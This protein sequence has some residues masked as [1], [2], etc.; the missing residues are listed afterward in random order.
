MAKL[1][2]QVAL[3]RE[4]RLKA[5]ELWS[6]KGARFACGHVLAFVQVARG[7]KSVRPLRPVQPGVWKETLLCGKC[8]F[9]LRRAGKIPKEK[10]LTRQ[11][12][13]VM[14]A[15]AWLREYLAEQ[16]GTAPLSAFTTKNGE[17]PPFGIT[18]L[19]SALKNLG[20]TEEK[21][22]PRGRKYWKLPITP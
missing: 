4:E 11:A 16:G 12:R 21:N 9:R 2:L 5:I 8:L 14:Q 13:K 6:I 17:K 18:T 7:A 19:R 20:G 22:G 3:M 15:E 1:T 10:I